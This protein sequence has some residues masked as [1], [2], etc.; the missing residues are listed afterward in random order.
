MNVHILSDSPRGTSAYASITRNLAHGLAGRGHNVTVTGFQTYFAPENHERI[1]VFP[2]LN[3]LEPNNPQLD[4]FIKNLKKSKADA[5][6][7]IFQADSH[8]NIYSQMFNPAY[9]WVPVEGRGLPANMSSDLKAPNIQVVSQSHAGKTE[10]ASEGIECPVIY[11][12][13]DPQVFTRNPAPYC[14]WST[15]LHR[16]TQDPVVLCT[17][18]CRECKGTKEGCNNFEEEQVMINYMG[19]EFSGSVSSLKK[20]R[21]NLRADFIVGC[22]A[23]NMGL[24][25]RLERLIEGFS[26][27]NKEARGSLLHIHTSLTSH[28]LPLLDI[29]KK[30]NVMDRVVLSYGEYPFGISDRGMNQIYNCFDIHATASGAEGF[31]MT[32]LESESCGIPQVAPHFGTFP[33]LLGENERGL[34]ASVAATQ[35]TENGSLRCLVDVQ[36]LAD[37][38]SALYIDPN[39]RRKLGDAAAEWAKQFT[40]DKAVQQ[41]DTLLMEGDEKLRIAQKVT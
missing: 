14:K 10:L 27:F 2:L 22:V 32:H 12:G 1:K 24:R 16:Q 18:G 37:K 17:R 21:E 4:Q 3:P 8:F 19:K 28:G 30:Y 25:K 33:E 38:M 20:L 6:I 11:P 9:F 41:W 29:A 13:W 15:E 26:L 35:M 36:S 5:L 40:W 34:L 23:T 7:C 39:L 31:G